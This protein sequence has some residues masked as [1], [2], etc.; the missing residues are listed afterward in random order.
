V[1]IQPHDIPGTLAT[2]KSKWKELASDLPF[3]TY[4]L[5]NDVARQYRA[6]QRWG[7]IVTYASGFAIF[8]ACMGLF[9]LASLNV[10]RR[11]KEIGIRKVLGAS[12]HGLA[13]L[14]SKEFLVLVLLGNVVAWPIAYFAINS[15][16]ENFAYRIEVGMSSFLLATT[17]AIFIAALTVSYQAI[18]VAL[19]NPVEALRYE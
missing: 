10:T 1:K 2:L 13:G 4:F 17:A 3:E 8:I 16:L 6:E 9:G 7:K 14:V 15:W 12:V 11:T 19:T 5:D 18:K